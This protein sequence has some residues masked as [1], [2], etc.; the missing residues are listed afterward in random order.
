[1]KKYFAMILMFVS[2]SAYA[3]QSASVDVSKLS[4]EQQ[5][6]I[7]KQVTELSTAPTN[8]SAT[9]RKEAEAWG[10]LGSNMGRAMVGAA[11]EVG[12]AANEFRQTSASV[13]T[14]WSK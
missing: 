13:V 14:Q 10:D 7:A 8:I 11:K 2:I 4:A 6:Q 1:M 12:V 3:A 9:V 5:A